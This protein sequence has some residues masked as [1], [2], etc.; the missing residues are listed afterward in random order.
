MNPKYS[1]E[2]EAVHGGKSEAD[3]GAVSPVELSTAF[4]YLDEG[5][6]PY[7]R[8]FN[9]PNQQIVTEK[10]RLLEQAAAGL[11][12]SSGMA[13]ISTTLMS[14]VSPGEHVVFQDAIYGGTQSL[15]LKEF[16]RL[17]IEFTFAEC[18][19]KALVEAVRPNTKVVYAETPANPLMQVVDLAQVA[20]QVK[21][22]GIT[23]VV[24]NTFA[25]PI[26]QNPIRLGFDVVVHS[27]T[28][29]LGGH[30]DVCF[31]A[32]VSRADLIERIHATSKLYGGSLNALSLYLVERSLKTLAVRV[33]QQNENAQ[34]IAEFLEQHSQVESVN[35]P[36]LKSHPHHAIACKQ[37]TG[38]GGM[39]SF[40]LDSDIQPIQFLKNLKLVT[41]AMSL[42]GVETT[43][44]L[45]ALTSHQ[46][47]PKEIREK[48]G[49]TDRLVRLSV[50]I[51]SVAD[52]INDFEQAIEACQ[53]NKVTLG[54]GLSFC[55]QLTVSKETMYAFSCISRTRC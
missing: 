28:K 18:S 52:L 11:V 43:V 49:I 39:L 47:V 42:G 31:G 45:P 21:G 15:I 36:G 13:A 5:P 40:E 10:I 32:V 19:A 26:N 24:D 51:E 55:V 22:Q 34:R 16:E 50:G 48:A 12:F 37:M 20:E 2:T 41:A 6:R 7:P 9:T 53:S 33:K 27:G 38:F 3:P 29:Y 46:P 44:T 25:S 8:Y 35:Y 17:G 30:S 14:L 4:K 23:T 1:I 54:P